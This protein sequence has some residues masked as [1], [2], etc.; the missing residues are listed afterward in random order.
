M[1]EKDLNEKQENVKIEKV[2]TEKRAALISVL[3]SVPSAILI[4]MLIHFFVA[5]PEE[6]LFS[7]GTQPPVVNEG[8]IAPHPHMKK[9]RRAAPPAAN[10]AV[11]PAAR[12]LASLYQEKIVLAKEIY[13]GLEN[14]SLSDQVMALTNI[15]L[16]EGE[17]YRYQN[18][19]RFWGEPVSDLAIRYEAAQKIAQ[20]IQGAKKDV[21]A[22]RMAALNLEIKLRTHR[23]FSNPEWES[24]YSAYLKKPDIETYKAML[25]AEQAAQRRRR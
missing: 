3:I 7:C 20:N 24:A 18:K 6:P 21:E 15:M 8:Q 11:R 25:S 9:G 13:K 1:E 10:A 14:A 2:L 19:M 17:L 22:A 12:D 5:V 16:A 23:V 4:G